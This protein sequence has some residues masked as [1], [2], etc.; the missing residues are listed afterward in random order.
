M[1]EM[2][3]WF[4]RL[5]HPAF[6]RLNRGL[7]IPSSKDRLSKTADS[8]SDVIELLPSYSFEDFYFYIIN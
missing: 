1:V 3:L 2:H 6:L 8:D 4:P 5:I 7:V